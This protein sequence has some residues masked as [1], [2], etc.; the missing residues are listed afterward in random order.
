MSA[1]ERIAP[2]LYAY[3]CNTV[4]DTPFYNLIGIN[5]ERIE[6]GHAVL[7]V[8]P[9]EDHLNPLGMVHGGLVVTLADAA[10]GNA[11]RSMGIKGV[12]ADITVSFISP[13]PLGVKI[14][15]EGRVLKAGQNLIFA[16]AE[17]WAEKK[18]IAKSQGT[19]FKTGEISLG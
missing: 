7:S 16:E 6:K 15:A 17:V 4:S 2:E 12:T 9:K 11:I 10:M 18:L 5:L 1:Y 19:F 14:E 13:P 3:I 8:W